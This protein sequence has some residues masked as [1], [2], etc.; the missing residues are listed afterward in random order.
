MGAKFEGIHRITGGQVSQRRLEEIEA[1]KKLKEPVEEFLK[2]IGYK[3]RSAPITKEYMA[4][5]NFYGKR[6]GYTIAI[7]AVL[8]ARTLGVEIARVKTVTFQ[9]GKDVDYVLLLPLQDESQ[10]MDILCADEDKEYKKIVKEG[11]VIWMWDPEKQTALSYFN[12][13]RDEVLREQ[14]EDKGDIVAKTRGS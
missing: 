5:P 10:L 12:S 14:I 8:D 9:M 6:E 3:S 1:K 13:L 2:A 4:K 11:F 7:Y